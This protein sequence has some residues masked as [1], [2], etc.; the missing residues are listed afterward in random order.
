MI[1]TLSQM[2]EKVLALK[3]KHRIAVA[4]ASDVNS[5]GAIDRA[6]KNGLI[7]AFLIGNSSEIIKTCRN[8]SI[9]DK[10]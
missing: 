9:D 8:N 10:N 4:W 6:V 1:R 5:I 7:E 2:E 3:I